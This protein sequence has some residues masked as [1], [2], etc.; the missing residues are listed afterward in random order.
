MCVFEL[1]NFPEFE[2]NYE[3]PWVSI[4]YVRDFKAKV[5]KESPPQIFPISLFANEVL[6]RCYIDMSGCVWKA[7]YWSETIFIISLMENILFITL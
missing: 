6:W 7:V 1:M 4:D 3:S 5:A 2:I